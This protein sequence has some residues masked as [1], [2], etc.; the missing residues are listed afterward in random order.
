MCQARKKGEQIKMYEKSK[1]EGMIIEI[2]V[3]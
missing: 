1:A 2:I 3:T